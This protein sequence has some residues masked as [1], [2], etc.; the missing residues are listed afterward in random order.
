MQNLE[1]GQILDLE[2]EIENSCRYKKGG[3]IVIDKKDL[4]TIE[5]MG[6]F[7]LKNLILQFDRHW[8]IIKLVIKFLLVIIIA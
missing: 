4:I 7:D 5:G 6:G 3:L 8:Q 1:D 2:E